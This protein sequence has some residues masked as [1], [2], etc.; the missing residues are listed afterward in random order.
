MK[1]RLAWLALL[2]CAA[3]AQAAD[4]FPPDPLAATMLERVRASETPACIVVGVVE[5]KSRVAFACSKEAGPA[6]LDRDSI[7][8]IG[9]VTKGITGILLADM[10]LK[11]EVS[12]DDAAARHS[13][14]G[15]KL[16]SRDGR[17]IR[18]RDLVT[19][20]SGL[21]RSPPGYQPRDPQN[22]YNG[23]D[24]DALYAA[25]AQTELAG[26]VGATHEYSN[27]G[28][29]WLSE[30]LARAGG[31]PFDALLAERVL[32]PLGMKDT[33][34]VLTPS[35]RERFVTGHALPYTATPP[36]DMAVEVVGAGGLR[37]SMS[38]MLKLGEALAGR[39][40]TPLDGAI[41][42]A[43]EPLRPAT[44]GAS[45]GFGWIAN[46]RTAAV[47][48]H[49]HNGGTGGFHA[50]VAADRA[51]RRAAIVLVDS[52]ASFDD[53]ALHIVDPAIPLQKKR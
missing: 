32:Q 38:D 17:A 6:R 36:W 12:L 22:P 26:E 19:H 52:A 46:E 45:I 42:L 2:A 41:A 9:S 15:A 53:L 18:L 25:L 35:Q 47:P 10:V 20:T 30:I 8:E 14:P 44:G 3:A 33:A 13:R 39:R 29:M 21:P 7:F 43:L 51:A 37:S 49:W 27:F 5:Q 16:P 24:A 31:K 40:K 34:I 28:Y 4:Q 1:R 23:F 50:M 11:G 48:L